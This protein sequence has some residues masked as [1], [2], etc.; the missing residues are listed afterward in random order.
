MN[1]PFQN[2][3][4]SPAKDEPLKEDIRYLGRVLGN[5]VRE[6]EG[7]EVFEIVETIR[8]KS[9]AWLRDG[10]ASAQQEVK[11]LLEGLDPPRTVQVVRAFSYF[12]HLANLAEDQHHIR[13]TRAHEIAKSPARNG[14]M[15]KAFERAVNEGMD[16][17]KLQEFFNDANLAAVLTAH[18]TEVRRKSTMKREMALADLLQQ[19]D[20]GNLTEREMVEIDAKIKRAILILWETNMLRQTKLNVTDEVANGLSYYEYT[21]YL[22]NGA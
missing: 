10:D 14:T 13:R 22:C 7:D 18:P 2:L 19:R 11:Q 21:C 5:I 9:I 3:D 6:Q 4:T 16:A 8:Q 20:R 17:A 12:S 15:E 1:S